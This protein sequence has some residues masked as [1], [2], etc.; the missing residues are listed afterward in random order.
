MSDSAGQI[1]LL[2]I[3]R[4][5][6]ELEAPRVVYHVIWDGDSWSSPV[7]VYSVAGYPEFPRLAISAGNHLHAVWFVRD[8]LYE[9][10]NY[11][12]WYS[13]SYST[14]PHEPPQPSPV[15]TATQ[16]IAPT[17][18]ARPVATLRPTLASSG[19]ALQAR[20]PTESGQVVRVAAAIAPIL[21][22]L[23]AVVGR[24]LLYRRR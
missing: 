3:G 5:S 10:G 12:V 11:E 21:L 23:L 13:D 20:M 9:T 19:E 24:R 15:P 2:A 22:L 16:V 8:R 6:P 17:A 7:K 14:A 1:H 18:T 4:A